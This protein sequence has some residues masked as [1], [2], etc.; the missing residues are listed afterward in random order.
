MLIAGS[1]GKDILQVGKVE[2]INMNMNGDNFVSFNVLDI[3]TA[4]MGL[5]LLG[6]L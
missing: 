3:A 6:M 2:L 5:P 4:P 1:D